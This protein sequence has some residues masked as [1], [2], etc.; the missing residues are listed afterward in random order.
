MARRRSSSNAH[1]CG[2]ET[3]TARGQYAAAW[4]DISALAEPANAAEATRLF[5]LRQDVALRAGQPL[6]AVR[7]GVARERIATTDAARTA[8]RRDLLTD[9]R[10]AI[11]RGL[12][13]DPAA[14][15][16][17]LL[18][19][20]LEVGQIAAAAGRS[21]LGAEAALDRWRARFP[22]HPAATIAYLRDRGAGRAHHAGR[23]ARRQRLHR[24]AAA[25]LG[26]ECRRRR[27]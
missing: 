9:L 11:D 7:A 26:L 10:G 1:W 13:I 20:W 4:R 16:E 5:R 14:A 27:S 17:P 6:E 15:R 12:R 19:G 22:G 3:A 25:A 23:G 18:R 21:P 8:A 24:T 2:A